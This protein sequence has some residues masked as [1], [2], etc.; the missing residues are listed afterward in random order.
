M[1]GHQMAEAVPVPVDAET[2][3]QAERDFGMAAMGALCRMNLQAILGMG[4]FGGFD[5]GLLWPL[6]GRNR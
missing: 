1:V 3:G 6:P 5:E 2:V 4:G